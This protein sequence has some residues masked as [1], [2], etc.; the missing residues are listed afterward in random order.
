M[1]EPNSVFY[2]QANAIPGPS[3]QQP[4]PPKTVPPEKGNDSQNGDDT[5]SSTRPAKKKAAKGKLCF[6]PLDLKRLS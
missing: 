5:K 2:S 1:Q 6:A 3:Y 4:L